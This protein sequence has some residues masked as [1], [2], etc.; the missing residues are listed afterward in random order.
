MRQRLINP[1]SCPRL[2]YVVQHA[3]ALRATLFVLDEADDEIRASAGAML[4]TLRADLSAY[5]GANTR[6]ASLS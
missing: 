5:V 3:D 1:E 6:P 2:A 4:A